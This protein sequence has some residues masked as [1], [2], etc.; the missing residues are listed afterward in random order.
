MKKRWNYFLILALLFILASCDE[1]IGKWKDN[2]KLS[3]K[4]A[5]LS[6]EEDSITI[7]TEG[8]W[9][10]INNIVINNEDKWYSVPELADSTYYVINLDSII[11]ERKDKNTLVVKTKEN[12]YSTKRNI[13]ITLEAG[14]YFDQVNITQKGK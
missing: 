1:S 9:W 13:K 14:N 2:I 10:W 11:I 8:T 12:F 7:K 5:V 6:S 4:Y 3:T